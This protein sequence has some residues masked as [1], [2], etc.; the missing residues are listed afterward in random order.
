[1]SF[2]K[3]ITKKRAIVSACVLILIAYLVGYAQIAQDYDKRHAEQL[4]RD[5][6]VLQDPA[7]LADAHVLGINTDGIMLR[8]SAHPVAV[9]V[10]KGKVIA[11]FTAPNLIEIKSSQPKKTEIQSV[12]YEYLHYVWLN[13]TPQFKKTQGRLYDRYFSQNSDLAYLVK[14]YV[15]PA[16]T[17]HDEMHSTLCALVSPNRLSIA[18]NDYCNKV[19][20]NRSILF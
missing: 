4:K 11:S 2:T 7:L 9:D 18:F 13:S 15:G 10:P 5:K 12:A 17:I 3:K 8:Y 16:D 14:P 20:P 6:I 1:M 19:I